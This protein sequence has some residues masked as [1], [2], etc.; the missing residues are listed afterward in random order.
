[1]LFKNYNDLVLNGSTPILQ[2]KRKDVLDM[3][4]AAVDAVKPYDVVKNVF[5]GSQLVF[6]SETIDLSSFDHLYLAGFGKASAGMA[7]AVCDAV[8]VTNGVVITNDSSAQVTHDSIEVIVGGHPLPNEN[9][10]LGAEKIL[11]LF[12]ECGD[13]D[14]LIVLISG[15]GSSLFCKPLVPLHDLQRT[16]ELLLRSGATISEVNTIRKHLSMVKG[17]QLIQHTKA[18]VISLIISDIVYDP[19]SSIA[20]G[21]T[22]PDPTTFSEVKEILVRFELWGKIPSTVRMVVE[23]GLKGH[24]LE[25]LK[26]HDPAFEK[27]FNFIV[28][29]NEAACQGALQ[30][31]KELGYDGKLLSTSITGEAQVIGRYLADRALSSLSQGKTAFISGG[32][33]TVAVSG[34][35]S[36][37]RN[38]ELVLGCV[39]DIA[40]KDTVVASFATDGIDGNSDVAGALADGNTLA[41]AKKKKLDPRRFLEENNSSVFFKG[42]GDALCTGS[43][44]T[45]VMDIQILIP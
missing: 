7:Q 8:P 23:K 20:S 13:G 10:I 30:K 14:C 18:V 42:L 33:T 37:G 21:P 11:H 15:G 2:Q 27:V 28:A 29:N 31:A 22:A 41:R 45:N 36:G 12:N 6:T 4:A 9:S 17:G 26:E 3:L 35:G 44:G 43:T 25:T 1:M 19:V 34:N 40:G 24:I 32:E 38:Q 5:C 39:S 16:I